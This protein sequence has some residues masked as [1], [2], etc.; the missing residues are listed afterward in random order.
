MLIASSC[1]GSSFVGIS[2]PR[3]LCSTVRC[4]W[5]SVLKVMWLLPNG[6]L[7]KVNPAV[8]TGS[9]FRIVLIGSLS[10]SAIYC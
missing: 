10:F 3:L 7:R 2:M 4:F 9:P 6:A 8:C 1:F 5:S